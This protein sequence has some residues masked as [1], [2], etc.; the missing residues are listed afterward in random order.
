MK[1]RSECFVLLHRHSSSAHDFPEN[2]YTEDKIK[3]RKILLYAY[4][5]DLIELFSSQG[6][7]KV[8]R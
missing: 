4:T 8:V 5:V 1:P 3:C 6:I 7:V 2:L